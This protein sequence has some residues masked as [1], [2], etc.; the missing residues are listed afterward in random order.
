[1]REEGVSAFEKFFPNF[2]LSITELTTATRTITCL[3]ADWCEAAP[4]TV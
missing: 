2:E 4:R 1:V 3:L